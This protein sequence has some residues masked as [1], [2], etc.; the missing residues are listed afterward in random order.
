MHFIGFLLRDALMH[1]T[2]DMGQLHF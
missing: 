1:L 2:S